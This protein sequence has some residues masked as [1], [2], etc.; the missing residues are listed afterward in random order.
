MP[1]HSCQED[2]KHKWYFY[3]CENCKEMIPLRDDHVNDRNIEYCRRCNM[4]L[5]NQSKKG[6]NHHNWK[7]GITPEYERLRHTSKLI[8]WRKMIYKRDNYSCQRCGS[9]NKLQAHHIKKFIDYPELRYD[10]SNG[11]TLCKLCHENLHY[12]KR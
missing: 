9:N 6:E 12:G 1:V 8:S 4:S 3:I 5:I 2:G 10:I 7:G 11:I